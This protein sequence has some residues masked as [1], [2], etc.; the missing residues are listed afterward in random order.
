MADTG[1]GIEDVNNRLVDYGIPEIWEPHHPLTVEEP[2]TPEP[3]EAYSKEELDYFVAVL[4]KVAQ[5]CYDDPEMVKGAPH[6][7][8]KH[9]SLNAFADKFEDI[10][11]TWRQYQKKYVQ[12]KKR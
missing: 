9:Q 11:S 7:A 12:K 5:E 2:F 3:T 1:C 4:A 10:A 6:K 8:S